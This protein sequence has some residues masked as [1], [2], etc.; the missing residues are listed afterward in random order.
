LASLTRR[1]LILALCRALNYGVILLSPIFL[2]RIFD[3]TSYGQYREFVLYYFLITG[4]LIFSVGVNPLYFIAKYP[5]KARQI[6]SHTAIILFAISIV[7]S[8]GVFLARNYILDRTSYDFI[9]AL[10]LYVFFFLNLEYFESYSLGRKRSDH[11]LYYSATRALLRIATIITVA[12]FTR[13][14]IAVIWAIVALEVLK[15]IF[16]LIVS[17]KLFTLKL[18]AQLLKEQVRYIVP[19][20]SSNAITRVNVDLAKLVVSTTLGVNGLAIYSIGNYQVPI[21]HAVRSSI[22]DVL[23]PEMTKA[24]E[25]ERMLMWKRAAVVLCFLVFPVFVVFFWNAETVI[26]TLF[27]EKYI[28]AVPIFKVYLTLMLIQCFDMAIPLRAIN[29][30]KYIFFGNIIHLIVNVSFILL[31]FKFLGMMAPPIAYV[32]GIL[33]FTIYLAWKVLDHYPLS[34]RQLVMWRKVLTI[35]MVCLI[36]LPIL[37]ADRYFDLHPVLKAVVFSLLFMGAYLFILTRFKID[38]VGII[39]SKFMGMLKRSPK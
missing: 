14:V 36:S 12:Y 22:M 4:L 13:S 3:V 37:Y 32:I 38:E 19:L 16:M 29:K 34:L 17:R 25:M 28:N 27:G 30:N 20:G 7:G 5:E 11:V 18:D 15:C 21:I 23:F 9:A 35:V 6:I 2:V 39:V 31:T 8:I 24:D 26:V 33:F 10:I 1:T